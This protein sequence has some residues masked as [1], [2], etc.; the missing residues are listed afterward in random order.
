MDVK[1]YTVAA[2]LLHNICKQNL[3]YT[4]A[5]LSHFAEGHCLRSVIVF[6]MCWLLD[7]SLCHLSLSIH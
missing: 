2:L 4:I 6:T 3:E 7:C 5:R 1:R